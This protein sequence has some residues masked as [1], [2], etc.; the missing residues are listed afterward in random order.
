MEH[1][2]QNQRLDTNCTN[3]HE[4]KNA[5]T[6]LQKEHHGYGFFLNTKYTNRTKNKK[7]T[8]ERK[9]SKGMIP[10]PAFMLS[11]LNFSFFAV[12]G[13]SSLRLC[14]SAVK[15]RN[16]ELLHGESQMSRR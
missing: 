9:N 12:R 3:F 11:L 8:E 2:F 7:S 16:F 13:E 6:E 5:W 10:F 15:N 1:G 14:A 4:L